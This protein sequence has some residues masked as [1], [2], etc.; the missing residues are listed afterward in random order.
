MKLSV[1]IV[2]YN[3]RHFLEHALSSV[4]V[5]LQRVSGEV[6]VVDNS[7]VDDSCSMVKTLFPQ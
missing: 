3:V 6:I 1:I 7:S 4:M 2:N 5:A